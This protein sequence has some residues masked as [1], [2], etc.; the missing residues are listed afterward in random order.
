M[1]TEEQVE[2]RNSLNEELKYTEKL[3][4]TK[5]SNKPAN[6]GKR[7]ANYLLDWI[8]IYIFGVIFGIMLGVIL[9]IVSIIISSP[10]PLSILSEDNKLLNF[11]LGF[12]VGMIYYSLFEG[13][14]GRTL[15]KFITRTK[16]ITENGEKPDFKTI[17]LRSLCRFVPFDPLSF[18]FSGKGWH[19]KWS[20]TTVVN[21]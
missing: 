9:V 13:L 11:L 20:R 19:D 17:L 18:L 1:N 14:T 5:I 6:E 10:T 7:I 8:F 2:L 15:A 4:E 3:T 21:V 12:I 16:V